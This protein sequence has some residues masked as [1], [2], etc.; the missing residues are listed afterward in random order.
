MGPVLAA[1][2]YG[3]SIRMVLVIHM[4]LAVLGMMMDSIS[5]C[6]QFGTGIHLADKVNM[7]S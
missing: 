1:L 4:A 7:Q 2:G 6:R 5:Y 3:L